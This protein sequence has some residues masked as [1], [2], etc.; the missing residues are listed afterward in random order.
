MKIYYVQFRAR[1]EAMAQGKPHG[2]YV[3]C[4]IKAGSAAAAQSKAEN[5]I[6]AEGWQIEAVEEPPSIAV[7]TETGA[8]YLEQARTDDEVYVYHTWSG[9]DDEPKH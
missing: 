3:S 6:R 5:D 4:W 1:P 2:A 8:E 7:P 9:T